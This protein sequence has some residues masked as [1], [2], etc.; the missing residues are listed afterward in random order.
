VKQE[1]NIKSNNGRTM[2]GGL[3]QPSSPQISPLLTGSLH[4]S[5]TMSSERLPP[6]ENGNSSPGEFCEDHAEED[7]QNPSP[8]RS[9]TGNGGKTATISRRRAQPAFLGAAYQMMEECDRNLA[10]WSSDGQSFIVWD[11]VG[12]AQTCIPQHFKHSNFSSFVRQM[13]F[14]GFENTRVRAAEG[15]Q[16]SWQ[17]KHPKFL[18]GKSDLLGDIKRKTYGGNGDTDMLAGIEQVKKQLEAAERRTEYWENEC[19]KYARLAS[20]APGE[21][22]KMQDQGPCLLNCRHHAL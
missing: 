18:R 16:S 19:K 8:K 5:S 2:K 1:R 15:K 21:S 4:V 22:I 7:N 9:A 14:Y 12:F 11:P 3:E 17:F 13:N 20:N 10:S 6:Q